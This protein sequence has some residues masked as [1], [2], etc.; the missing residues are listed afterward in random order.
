M[1]RTVRMDLMK[2]SPPVC[3]S[4]IGQVPVADE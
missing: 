4:R 2:V 3:I 1:G